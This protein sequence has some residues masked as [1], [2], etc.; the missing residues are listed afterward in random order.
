[1]NSIL[2]MIARFNGNPKR[3]KNHKEFVREYA[4]YSNLKSLELEIVTSEG[5]YWLSLLSSIW[6]LLTE[7]IA[8]AETIKKNIKLLNKYNGGNNNE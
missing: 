5:S 3:L 7:E 1:M 8:G 4:T 2:F 6:F